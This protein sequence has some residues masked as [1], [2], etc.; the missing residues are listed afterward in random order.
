MCVIITFEGGS[1]D[2]KF[3][4]YLGFVHRNFDS[5]PVSLRANP[6]AVMLGMEMP[7]GVKVSDE[8]LGTFAPIIV[9]WIYSGIYV[10]LGSLDNYRL[11]TRKDE[12]EKNL[13]SKGDVVKGV[14]LQQAVQAVVATLLFAVSS[15]SMHFVLFCFS[16]DFF[17]FLR[18]C[19]F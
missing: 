17:S 5:L 10:L 13:V 6:I 14:L 9:Y 15:F 12:D 18:C 1:I 11:H 3:D 19:A 2:P 7:S 8:M 16:L 4:L